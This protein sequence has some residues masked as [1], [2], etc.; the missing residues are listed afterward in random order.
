MI[1][2]DEGADRRWRLTARV[3]TGLPGDDW[4]I[5]EGPNP[6]GGE[7]G[8]TVVELVDAENL[9]DELKALREAISAAWTALDA[10]RLGEARRALRAA[11][12]APQGLTAPYS[13]HVADAAREYQ[14][15]LETLA[16]VIENRHGTLPGIGSTLREALAEYGWKS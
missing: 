6:G 15:L 14:R 5:A 1:L 9:L 13:Q 11:Y 12:S 4:H 8:I 3:P 16:R 7:E 2:P 10:G